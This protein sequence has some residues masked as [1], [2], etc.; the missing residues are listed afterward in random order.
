MLALQAVTPLAL[1]HACA[2]LSIADARKV[3]AAVDRGVPL[4][5]VKGVRRAAID[6][7]GALGWVPT[8]ELCEVRRSAVDPFVKLGLRTHDGHVVEAVRIPLERAGRF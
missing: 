4:R 8:L 2:V 3:V 5:L 1:S 7:V 6:A